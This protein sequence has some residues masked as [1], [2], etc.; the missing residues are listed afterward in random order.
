MSA[1]TDDQLT[2]LEMARFLKAL[3]KLR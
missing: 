1:K 3:A 2:I